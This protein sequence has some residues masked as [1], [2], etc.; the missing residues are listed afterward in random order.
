[1]RLADAALFGCARLSGKPA[2]IQ[3]KIDPE[4]ITPT[5]TL[6]RIRTAAR[7]KQKG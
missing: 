6:T 1:L 2:I 7:A 3:L 4:A 5:T